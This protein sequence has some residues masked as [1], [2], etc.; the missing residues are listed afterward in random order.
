MQGHLFKSQDTL[1]KKSNTKQEGWGGAHVYFSMIQ[2]S[3]IKVFGRT[4]QVDSK[5]YVEAQ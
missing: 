5:I 3:L 2:K 4:K 1:K